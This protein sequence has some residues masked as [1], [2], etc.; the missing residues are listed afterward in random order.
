MPVIVT[1]ATSLK[2]NDFK[3]VLPGWRQFIVWIDF[4][5]LVT[6]AFSSLKAL[7]LH[8]VDQRLKVACYTQA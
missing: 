2:K 1:I 6:P 4:K 5:M 3:L 7:L 8:L